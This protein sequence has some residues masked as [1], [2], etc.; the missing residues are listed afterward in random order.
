MGNILTTKLFQ[1]D[2]YTLN[3]DG[4]EFKGILQFDRILDSDH[5]VYIGIGKSAF[6]V[7]RIGDF[8]HPYHRLIRFTEDTDKLHY[9]FEHNITMTLE[10]T[11]AKYQN[12]IDESSE[13]KEDIYSSSIM[14]S[15]IYMNLLYKNKVIS[16]QMNPFIIK[17]FK[18]IN[19]GDTSHDFDK[20]YDFFQN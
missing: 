19:L 13:S 17:H 6:Q 10:K 16:K 15:N 12:M 2:K 18:T 9:E 5:Q 20:I 3:N 1:R 14:K 11:L 8:T 4:T 7:I